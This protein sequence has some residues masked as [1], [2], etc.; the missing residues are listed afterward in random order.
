MTQATQPAPNA[1][2]PTAPPVT[3]PAAVTA[4]APRSLPSR[5][6]R[7]RLVATVVCL[8]AAALTAIQLTAT[9]Q[10]TR[11]AAADTAQLVRVQAVKVNLLHA[12][13][14]AT[15]AFLVGG[16]E[17]A[18]QRAAYDAA[19]R[20]VTRSI[21]D[22]AEAQPADRPVLSSL[23]EAV[24]DYASSMELA[25]AYNRQGFPVGAA[26]LNQA[27]SNLRSTALP[28]VDALVT[29]NQQRSQDA[30]DA[31]RAWLVVLPGLAAVVG[32]VLLNQWVAARFRRRVNVGLALA[33]V[34]TLVATLAAGWVT[35]RQGAENGQLVK[36]DYT[37]VVAGSKARSAG[38]D[39][40]A[41]ESLRLISRGSGSTY[42]DKWK[43]AAAT[44]T[45][46]PSGGDL[47]ALGPA[48]SAY[49]VKH[50]A[51]VAL[52]GGGQW[53][54]AVQAATSTAAGS[55]SATFAT[56]DTAAQKAVDDAGART[57]S[58]L[59]GGLASFL[60]IAVLAV[61]AGLVAA[62]ASWRGISQRLEEYS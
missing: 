24:L 26:Y 39:A 17:P 9:W 57:T 13:A 53:D 34:L 25:R 22:A 1:P 51:I 41:N 3:A 61:L 47:A 43:A 28:L 36:G 56:F 32:L 15:N 7:L 52:D 11:A 27:S 37:A 58:A 19:I 49:A 12:D 44:V 54:N 21:A 60:G 31:P 30:M 46:T 6:T 29:A 8:V 42:E 35:W 23:N 4:P 33:V 20:S 62:G 10:S 45:A 55:A 18:E 48:W 14:L 50:A 38:N 59:R 16:L 2:Q 5:L 40:K